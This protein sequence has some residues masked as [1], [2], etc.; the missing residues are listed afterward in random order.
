M[1][2]NK[3]KDLWTLGVV[4]FR[5]IDRATKKEE[6][7]TL[8]NIAR[9]ASTLFDNYHN[10]HPNTLH[11]DLG[12]ELSEFADLKDDCLA[13]P[14]NGPTELANSAREAAL[15]ILRKHSNS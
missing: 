6:T 11:P 14:V 2:K 13:D 3:E 10:L 15:R 1:D 4:L 9:Q 12:L 8:G 5:L 7:A